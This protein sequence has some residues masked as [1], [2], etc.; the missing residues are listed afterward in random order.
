MMNVKEEPKKKG[1]KFKEYWL[2]LHPT[3]LYWFKAEKVRR[4]NTFASAAAGCVL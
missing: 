1:S 3:G 4:K 2:V